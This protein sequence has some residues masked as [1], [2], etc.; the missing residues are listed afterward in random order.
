MFLFTPHLVDPGG[1][2]YTFI[3]I[4]EG[5]TSRH[6]RFSFEFGAENTY[7]SKK[8]NAKSKKFPPAAGL[9]LTSCVDLLTI[10]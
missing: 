1:K 6:R 9:K 7:F 5:E 8:R 4:G 3:P 2:S 10:I